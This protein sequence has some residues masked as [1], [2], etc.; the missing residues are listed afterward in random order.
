MSGYTSNALND[1]DRSNSR[2]LAL[3]GMTSLVCR[4][5][6]TLGMTER[7]VIPRTARYRPRNLL[8]AI[9]AYILDWSTAGCEL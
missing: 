2:S 4:S 8:Y 3:L 9:S 6:A 7:S 5:L 1:S